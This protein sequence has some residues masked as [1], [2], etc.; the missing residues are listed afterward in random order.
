MCM[1]AQHRAFVWWVCAV[2]LPE[3]QHQNPPGLDLVAFF[4]SI[5]FLFLCLRFQCFLL[6]LGLLFRC[7]FLVLG[8][9]FVLVLCLVANSLPAWLR[10]RWWFRW[11]GW[12]LGCRSFLLR[13][14]VVL[15]LFPTHAFL[16]F[17][18]LLL[19]LILSKTMWKCKCSG[20]G[21]DGC[22]HVDRTLWWHIFRSPC[23]FFSSSSTAT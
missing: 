4:Q 15:S 18:C 20:Y 10:L 21:I 17:L 2:H 9:V 12:W 1:H 11:W 7:F 19:L 3:K 8:L 13:L 6:T 23:L 22:V 16:P 5:V 14:L